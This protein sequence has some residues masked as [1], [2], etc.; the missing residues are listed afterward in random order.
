MLLVAVVA[1]FVALSPAQACLYKGQT[2][3]DG[4]EWTVQE[5]FVMKCTIN[6]SGSWKTAIVGCMSPQGA[7]I[8]INESRVE[9]ADEFRCV[10]DANGM[11]RMNQGIGRFSKCGTHTVGEQWV[12]G[13]FQYVC[14]PGGREEVTACVTPSGTRVGINSIVQENGVPVECVH[15]TNNGTIVLRGLGVA[16]DAKCMDSDG[17]THEIGTW[18]L[19]ET[20]FNKTCGTDGRISIAN[21]VTVDGQRVPVNGQLIANGLRYNCEKRNDGSVFF[22]TGAAPSN[23]L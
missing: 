22:R 9:G 3:V 4:D 12:K 5:M 14:Q 17:T 2:Y 21:C 6:Q 8:N 16:A 10:A 13:A 23:F 19:Q 18:W 1:L 15:F 20:H 11:V 7:K